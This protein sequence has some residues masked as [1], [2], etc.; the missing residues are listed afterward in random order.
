[1]DEMPEKKD[2]VNTRH[3]KEVPLPADIDTLR[4]GFPQ[5][6]DARKY[7]SG[8]GPTA[9]DYLD[10]K[11][12]TPKNLVDQRHAELL[13]DLRSQF[14]G[15]EK[16]TIESLAVINQTQAQL[17]RLQQVNDKT[18]PVPTA[19]E[20]YASGREAFYTILPGLLERNF[21]ML[22]RY[23]VLKGQHAAYGVTPNAE[24]E[25]A[26]QDQLAK[27]NAASTARL[28]L[29]GTTGGPAPTA[30]AFA[31]VTK[32][33]DALVE[34]TNPL[35]ALV[36]ALYGDFIDK[37][38]RK[39]DVNVLKKAEEYEVELKLKLRAGPVTAA[40]K[41]A[42]FAKYRAQIDELQKVGALLG[43]ELE[44][45][46]R[47]NGL[48]N[49]AD[50][51]E[52]SIPE[53]ERD[54]QKPATVGAAPKIP[55][56]E[57]VAA[58]GEKIA[59]S[60]IDAMTENFREHFDMVLGP[61][62]GRPAKGF[63]TDHLL[64]TKR[65]DIK[66]EH[67]WTKYASIR[68][69][70]V[71]TLMAKYR[72]GVRSMVVNGPRKVAVGITRATAGDTAADALD[73]TMKQ[74]L[75]TK[76]GGEYAK[77][78]MAEIVKSFGLPA[79]FDLTSD[80][81]WKDL[82][83]DKRWPGAKAQHEAKMLT[84]K[85]AI[86]KSRV[87][88]EKPAREFEGDLTLLD[89]LRK[90]ADPNLLLGKR[91]DPAMVQEYMKKGL[92][93]E[94]IAALDPKDAVRV[95]SAFVALFLQM[96]GNW[97]AYCRA[98]GKL[99]V[100][101]MGNIQRHQDTSVAAKVADA[102]MAGDDEAVLK[103][104]VFGAAGLAT[105]Y[106]LGGRGGLTSKP[107]GFRPVP[108]RI[109]NGV[110][111]L[112]DRI[113]SGRLFFPKGFWPEGADIKK[114]LSD[115]RARDEARAKEIT[116]LKKNETLNRERINELDRERAA[117]RRLVE[118]LKSEL[119]L[120]EAAPL[121]ADLPADLKTALQ[122][123]AKRHARLSVGEGAAKWTC[124]LKPDGTANFRGQGWT[125]DVDAAGRVTG[126]T[127]T[128]PAVS[129]LQS[130]LRTAA[131]T[132][133]VLDLEARHGIVAEGRAAPPADPSAPPEFVVNEAWARRMKIF[134]GLDPAKPM[135]VKLIAEELRE[136]LKDKTITRS[137]AL[138][139]QQKVAEVEAAAREGRLPVADAAVIRTRIREAATER[140]RLIREIREIK[141]L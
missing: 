82:E 65:W 103:W 115:L 25:K 117:D 4:A 1:M 98:M 44:S 130:S 6:Q 47:H 20:K 126:V 87:E 137:E 34:A 3:P 61:R 128:P 19:E 135:D 54:Y 83:G 31:A 57:K 8:A 113:R 88:V 24:Q 96:R 17:L 35:P 84:V 27:F 21:H 32:A 91:A 56:A 94:D 70:K 114:E 43:V 76:E 51:E 7:F 119:A 78:H 52:W 141:V 23:L 22:D 64:S 81:D 5:L 79:D 12:I 60:S 13:K 116:E 45:L 90:K 74:A 129:S 26:V 49:L 106:V 111:S 93:K 50:M 138:E 124:D 101:V 58:E 63:E 89:A 69:A 59:A 112:L 123:A 77:D 37:A 30:E 28:A 11:K 86:E 16:R 120:K 105:S 40:D 2:V 118:D 9:R 67:A 95:I 55:T 42:I 85:D 122:D 140:G 71:L 18:R 66:A 100:L 53:G 99:E 72:G 33:T 121:V 131:D 102:G 15:N 39:N 110:P 29:W 46:V 125:L 68:A 107:V 92:T 38:L 139:I 109:V 48:E 97:N 134:T 136:A 10:S 75:S 41:Q 104:I 14:E 133:N 62:E 80:K 132:K 108:F 73:Y 127:G 36:N